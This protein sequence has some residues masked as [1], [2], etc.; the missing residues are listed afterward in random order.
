MNFL[1]T[2][3]YKL[4]TD[5]RGF[6]ILEL[7]VVI[8]IVALISSLAFVGIQSA[9]QKGKDTAV[10]ALMNDIFKEASICLDRGSTLNQ[11][12]NTTGGGGLVCA[13][14]TLNYPALPVG[15]NWKYDLGT[16]APPGNIL[17]ETSGGRF[18][19]RAI[20]PSTATSTNGSITSTS[21]TPGTTTAATK[22]IYCEQVEGCKK[23]GF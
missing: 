18:Y 8:A 4:K 3:N 16:G 19:I 23:T 11:P 14:A 9:R 17:S 2:T 12:T 6:T 22:T 7:L 1:Q 10:L 13:V 5:L 21:T 15:S 20:S